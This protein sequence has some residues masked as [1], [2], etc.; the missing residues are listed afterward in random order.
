MFAACSL[1]RSLLEDDVY[2]KVVEAAA[3]TAL[4][5]G[6]GSD[7]NQLMFDVSVQFQSTWKRFNDAQC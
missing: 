5:R 7:V 1:L 2:R 4:P 3:V 6:S